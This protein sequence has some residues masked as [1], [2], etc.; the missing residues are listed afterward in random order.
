MMLTIC[1]PGVPMLGIEALEPFIL[2]IEGSFKTIASV[3]SRGSFLMDE[4]SSILKNTGKNVPN[5]IHL[6]YKESQ[7]SKSRSIESFLLSNI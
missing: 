7:Y 6:L 3:M 1:V 4:L 5:Y 2:A